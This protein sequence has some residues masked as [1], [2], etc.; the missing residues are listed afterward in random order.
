[1]GDLLHPHQVLEES[2]Q[3]L[4]EDREL[5]KRSAH[6]DIVPAHQMFSKLLYCLNIKLL[7]LHVSWNTETFILKKLRT[8]L[9]IKGWI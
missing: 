7:T 2:H 9:K 8:R 5:E 4:G 6:L 1:M 3:L